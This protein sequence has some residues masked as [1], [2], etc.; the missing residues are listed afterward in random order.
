M[1]YISSVYGNLTLNNSNM[2][3]K[4]SVTLWTNS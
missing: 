4:L 3:S 1:I 2:F